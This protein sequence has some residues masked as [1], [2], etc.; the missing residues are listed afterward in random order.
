MNHLVMSSCVSF[1]SPHRADMRAHI[2][3]A[4]LCMFWVWLGDWASAV[5]MEALSRFSYDSP[6]L[7][8]AI[9]ASS[10]ANLCGELVI[11]ATYVVRGSRL[12]FAVLR[13]RTVAT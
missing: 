3:M 12:R 7:R 8:L 10:S 6:G 11:D 4:C 9:T 13:E 2:A 1:S 5:A